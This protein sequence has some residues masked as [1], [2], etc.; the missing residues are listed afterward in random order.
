MKN[1]G[2]IISNNCRPTVITRNQQQFQVQF[3][4]MEALFSYYGLLDIFLLLIWLLTFL[5][6]KDL[7]REMLIMSILSMFLLP[8]TFVASR[9]AE[10]NFWQQLLQINLLDLLFAFTLAGIAASVYHITFGKQ[11]QRL[12]KLNKQRTIIVHNSIAQ[13][14]IISL[15]L[16]VLIFVW[17]V[18]ILTLLFKVP[19]FIS[20]F[21]CA[22]L[23]I[24]FILCHRHDLISDALW[25]SLLTAATLI[26]GSIFA[27]ILGSVNLEIAPIHNHLALAGVP[28]DLIFWGLFIGLL[29]GP[30]YE[31]VRNYQLK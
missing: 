1:H 27:S 21:L 23:I 10:E 11:Y 14:W 16:I 2:I 20:L 25:S 12:P 3:I 9:L 28:L 5:R 17:S 30:I 15:L 22:S 18:L 29:F 26:V 13:T 24:T 6:R 8:M 31:F 7:Q 19:L 4:R